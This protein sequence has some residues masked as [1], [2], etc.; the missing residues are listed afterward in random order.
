MEIGKPERITTVE[1]IV[2]PIPHE[3]PVEEPAGAPEREQAPA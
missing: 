1:P 3:A 2:E